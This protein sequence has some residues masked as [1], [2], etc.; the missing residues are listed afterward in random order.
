M[1]N[2]LLNPTEIKEIHAPEVAVLPV[3]REIGSA[4]KGYYIQVQYWLLNADLVWPRH[5]LDIL[6]RDFV[7]FNQLISR[8]L[9]DVG[10][11]Q[12]QKQIE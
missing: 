5:R 1:A 12:K 7:T 3:W 10:A 11:T 4:T 6:S 9:S 2:I 8:S